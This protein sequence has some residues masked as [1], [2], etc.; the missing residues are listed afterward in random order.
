ML[1]GK[2][3]GA[4]SSS[5]TY[6]YTYGGYPQNNV[7]EKYSFTSDGNSTDVGD[8]TSVGNFASAAGHS[9]ET[10][11]YWAGG[12]PWAPTGGV[13]NI[14]EKYSYTTDANATD[15]GDLFEARRNIAGTQ[16]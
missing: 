3:A 12:G 14:I 11:G 16:Y 1:V 10:Y 13:H 6:G 7:I 15:V 2:E 4:G 5:A 8:A 9:S